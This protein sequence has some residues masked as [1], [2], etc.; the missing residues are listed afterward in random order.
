MMP[1]LPSE[2]RKGTI[3]L[4]FGIIKSAMGIHQFLSRGLDAVNGE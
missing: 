1:K 4:V 2:P 3:E